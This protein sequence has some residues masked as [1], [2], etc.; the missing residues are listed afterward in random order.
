M[1]SLYAYA[2]NI[3]VYVMVL[4]STFTLL[5]C[6]VRLEIALVIFLSVLY[7]L[8]YIKLLAKIMT[9]EEILKAMQNLS[10]VN[11]DSENQGGNNSESGS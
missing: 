10:S 3:S 7:Y 8:K 1:P 2:E 6:Y 11:S 5:Y 9:A 4:T